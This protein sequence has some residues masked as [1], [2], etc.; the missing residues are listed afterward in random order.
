MSGI[1]KLIV[2][3][4]LKP[5]GEFCVYGRVLI[6]EDIKNGISSHG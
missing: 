5:L 1:E 2:L 3:G 4:C 6:K